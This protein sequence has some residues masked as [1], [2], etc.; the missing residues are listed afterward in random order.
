MPISVSPKL[1]GNDMGDREDRLSGCDRPSI[2]LAMKNGPL[3]AMAIAWWPPGITFVAGGLPTTI[4]DP[5]ESRFALAAIMRSWILLRSAFAS[6]FKE[7]MRCVHTARS[8]SFP[9][10]F[11]LPRAKSSMS[12]SICLSLATSCSTQ[13]SM[14]LMDG[15]DCSTPDSDREA[16]CMSK[17]LCRWGWTLP[18]GWPRSWYGRSRDVTAPCPSEW[19][20]SSSR[21]LQSSISMDCTA[22]L[23]ACSF[24]K[25]SRDA[26]RRSPR[27]RMDRPLFPRLA[28]CSPSA[29]MSA[30]S[31][32]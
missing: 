15:L 6:S 4:P 30:R 18:R 22:R 29:Y 12:P 10:A 23:R 1:W 3:C 28:S 32:P 5:R 19:R 16:R 9:A 14:A 24:R 20:D 2:E 31:F 21:R 26:W 11:S 27:S 7:R 25:S 17:V 8:F 13:V